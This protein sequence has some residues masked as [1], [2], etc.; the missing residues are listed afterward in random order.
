MKKISKDS[1]R[2]ALYL[3][4]FSALKDIKNEQIICDRF[5][6]RLGHHFDI[7]KAG[8]YLRDLKKDELIFISGIA[9]DI[10]KI[11][12]NKISVYSASIFALMSGNTEF[13]FDKIY[14]KD[15]DDFPFLDGLTSALIFPLHREKKP[16]G[17]AFFGKNNN[18]NI[19]FSEEEENILNSLLSLI[20]PILD[21]QMTYKELSVSQ[22]RLVEAI[23]N[24]KNFEQ[25]KNSFLYNITHELKTPLVTIVGYSEMLHSKDMGQL[26]PMQI[27]GVETILKNSNH[28]LEMIEDLLTFVNLSDKISN[29]DL[30]KINIV[31]LIYQVVK[32]FENSNSQIILDIDYPEVIILAD[33]YLLTKA[34]E[35]LVENAIKFNRENKPITIKSEVNNL[36]MKVKILIIDNGIGMD[37]STFEASMKNFV[38]ESKNLE[39]K[40]SGIGFGL[41]FVYKILSIHQYN[42]LFKSIKDKGTEIGF[43]APILSFK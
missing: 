17:F 39:R 38:Q 18:K 42:I 20:I 12:I 27:K 9:V 13:R 11:E 8:I 3:E 16:L 21:L 15:I 30:Q 2:L 33:P 25:I 10:N 34:I 35:H 7:Q 5:F 28:L 41:S 24:L 31:N 23:E 43:E 14:N 36:T 19:I 4:I 32:K 29:I 37:Y 40:Y 22:S 6:E 1:F 26:N